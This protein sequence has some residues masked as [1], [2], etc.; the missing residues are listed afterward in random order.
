LQLCRK[1]AKQQLN[2]QTLFPKTPTVHI[3]PDELACYCE[4]HPKLKVL[5]TKT[6]EVRTMH[7][8]PFYVHETVKYCPLNECKKKYRYTGLDTFLPPG[9]NFGYDVIEYIGDAVWSKSHTALQIQ[10]DLKLQNN[11]TISESEIAYLAK[12]FVIYVVDAH[13][14]KQS[15]IRRFLHRGGGYF[16]YFD[17]MHPG[18]GAAHLMCAIAEEISERISIV[19]GSVKLPKE[20]TETVAAFL[21]ELK[22]KYGDPLAGVCDML[23]SNLA[24][25]QEVFPSVSLLI[26]HFHYLRG[27]GKS[28]LEYENTLLDGFLKQYDVNS[29]LKEIANKCRA[30]I[31][32]DQ[33]LAKYLEY[34]EKTYQYH[35]SFL[36]LPEIVKTYFMVMWIRSHKQELNGYGFPFDRANL[37]YFQRMNK[38]FKTF[39]DAPEGCEELSE[40]KYFLASVFTDPKFR[41]AMATMEKKV[42]DFDQVRDIMKIAPT[43]GGNGLNDNGE[44]CDMTAMEKQLKKFVESDGIKNN[45]DSSYRKLIKQTLKYWKLLFAKP[46]EV[47]SP[48]G[49]TVFIYPQRT[50]NC[51]E[52]LFREFL[53]EEC[54]RTGMDTLGRK[55]RTMI[56]E[57][58]MMKNLKCPEYLK[59]ILNGQLSLAAR[60]AEL[61]MEYA[62]KQMEESSQ[63]EDAL[64]SGIRKIIGDVD[65]YKNFMTAL[66]KTRKI[67]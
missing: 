38:I 57:T 27:L 36:Q 30:T 59:I 32:A 33:K 63:N 35:S 52:R 6:R 16:L 66:D 13:K 25:F 65:F 43:D 62:R 10:V 14:D 28:F 9:S 17:A 1:Q 18:D 31:D 46:V 49:E 20:S 12:K 2:P 44:E 51:M 23:A 40:L 26:C 37:V 5:K 24:A 58:P 64:P 53:R 56:A 8:G 41:V 50:S 60:F 42:S 21:R 19:L 11:L 47:L 55:A 54:K 3:E 4:S 67:A 29:R 15:E 22:E 7:I 34:D 39:K 48:N 45:I 61:D